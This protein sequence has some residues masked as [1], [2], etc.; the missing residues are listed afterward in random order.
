MNL[1]NI[2]AVGLAAGYCIIAWRDG[3]LFLYVIA[4]LEDGML[5]EHMRRGAGG[6]GQAIGMKLQ[7]LLLCPLCLSPWV[8]M[9]IWC[10]LQSLDLTSFESKW[11]VIPSAFASAAIAWGVYHYLTIKRK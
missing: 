1:E 10:V 9:F 5:A 6:V 7:Q 8:C 11:L 2:L 3:S 4:W